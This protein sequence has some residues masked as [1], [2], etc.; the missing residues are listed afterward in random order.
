MLLPKVTLLH[1]KI[2]RADSAF[3]KSGFHFSKRVLP[4][5]GQL[6]KLVTCEK[7]GH[8]LIRVIST[9]IMSRICGLRDWPRVLFYRD[10]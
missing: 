9:A 7:S 8:L 2:I 10:L 1:L 5:S 6:A 3:Q 4:N